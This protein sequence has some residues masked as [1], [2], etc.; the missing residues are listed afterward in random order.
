[1]QLVVNEWLPQYFL[2]SASREEKL[3]LQ[4]FLQC[5][6]E[7][8]DCM[9]VRRPS[10]F[11]RKIYRYAKELRG[12]YEAVTP[13]RNFIKLILEDSKRCQLIDDGGTALPIEAEKKLSIGNFS[14][15]RYLFEAALQTEEKTI[16][17]TDAKLAALMADEII[18]KVVLLDDFLQTYCTATL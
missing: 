11:Y 16:V 13:I 18:F 14:S 2:P 15:D 9:V 1:M 3:L 5:F 10:E 4:Q 12:N 6:I 8:D 7:R 17:T